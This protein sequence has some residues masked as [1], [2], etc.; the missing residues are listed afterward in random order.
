MDKSEIWSELLIGYF[1]NWIVATGMKG[2]TATD[3][4]S[5]QI[6]AAHRAKTIDRVECILG[7]SW[8]KSATRRK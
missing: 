6:A 2:M 3:S 7:A 1:W 5:R 4:H 8:C